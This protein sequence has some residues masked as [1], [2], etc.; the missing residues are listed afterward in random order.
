[1]SPAAARVMTPSW[2]RANPYEPV[3][4][5]ARPRTIGPATP[6][7]PHAVQLNPY[8]VESERRPKWRAMRYG[9]ISVSPPEPNPRQIDAIR[10]T[11]ND[12]ATERANVPPAAISSR[13]TDTRAAAKRSNSQ[14]VTTLPTR[15]APDIAET[16]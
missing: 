7:S 2:T 1:M 8:S 16:E 10:P 11:P 3:T 4:S 15:L 14:P 9:T 13:T 5:N 12:S 6:A